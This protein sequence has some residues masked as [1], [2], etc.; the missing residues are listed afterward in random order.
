MTLKEIKT[1]LSDKLKTAMPTVKVY[2]KEVKQG[3]TKPALFVEAIPV[4]TEK[5]VYYTDKTISVKIR[6]FSESGEYLDLGEKADSLIDLFSTPLVVGETTITISNTN[7]EIISGEE[8]DYLDFS[9]DLSYTEWAE[10][11]EKVNVNGETVF[12]LPD[13]AAGY[14]QDAISLIEE[15]NLNLNE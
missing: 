8:N 12:M 15:L 1:V 6:Y 9:F 5:S 10:V 11:L 7:S 13:E 14:T 2:A 3:F 4:S